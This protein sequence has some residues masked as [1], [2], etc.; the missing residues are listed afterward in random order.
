MGNKESLRTD[1]TE[2]EIYD[3]RGVILFLS[4]PYNREVT[5]TGDSIMIYDQRINM[6]TPPHWEN[7]DPSKEETGPVPAGCEIRVIGA[8]VVLGSVQWP[9]P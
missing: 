6:S 5:G 3:I 7:Q 9:N 1:A 2:G 4:A 8:V